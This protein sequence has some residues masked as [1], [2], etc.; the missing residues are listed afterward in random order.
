MSNKSVFCIATSH[1]QADRI[2]D[3]LKDANFSNNSISALFPDKSTTRDFAHEKSTKAPEGAAAGAG[4][5]AILGGVLGWLAGIGAIAVPG[6]GPLIAAGPIMG[7]LAGAGVGGRGQGQT[8]PP[9]NTRRIISRD[10]PLDG[11]AGRSVKVAWC[12]T[13]FVVIQLGKTCSL[14]V[15]LA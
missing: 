9:R 13:A 4:T 8:R 7:L 6:V 12:T 1:A 15:K 5:G 2:V 10:R 3:C 14:A 11:G